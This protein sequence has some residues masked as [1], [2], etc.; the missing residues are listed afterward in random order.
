MTREYCAT[1]ALAVSAQKAQA[2]ADDFATAQAREGWTR[3]L[4]EW[5]TDPEIFVGDSAPLAALA[6]SGTAFDDAKMNRGLA[7][8]YYSGWTVGDP[9]RCRLPAGGGWS[10]PVTWLLNT[11]WGFYFGLPFPYAAN[12]KDEPTLV[13]RYRRDI[14]SRGS[15]GVVLAPFHYMNLLVGLTNIVAERQQRTSTPDVTPSR[16]EQSWQLKVGVGGTIDLNGAAVHAIG[17]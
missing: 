14:R 6:K 11:W 1:R 15:I 3:E 8:A 9:G 10:V 7:I 13:G 4:S 2:S 16:L 5:K 12:F 17:K